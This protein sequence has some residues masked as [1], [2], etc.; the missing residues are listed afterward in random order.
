MEQAKKLQSMDRKHCK[1][2]SRS[3]NPPT[4]KARDELSFLSVTSDLIYITVM[5]H[6]TRKLCL[7]DMNNAP[8]QRLSQGSVHPLSSASLDKNGVVNPHDFLRPYMEFL[9]PYTAFLY[10]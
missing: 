3:N 10:V 8:L 5:C 4:I 1:V 2:T 7:M 6:K 9:I